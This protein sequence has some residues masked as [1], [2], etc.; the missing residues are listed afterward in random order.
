[1]ITKMRFRLQQQNDELE[2]LYETY[3]L[4]PDYS[5]KP[6]WY[7]GERESYSLIKTGTESQLT[8]M[9]LDS[10]KAYL[11]MIPNATESEEYK[12]KLTAFR[13]RMID[14][15]NPSSSTLHLLLGKIGA[16][17]FMKAAVM[18][19]DGEV[20]PEIKEKRGSKWLV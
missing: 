9:A 4:L 20:L 7:V 16:E 2:Q 11:S 6:N 18:P 10:V 19:I 8:S 15:G 3:R 1:M 5:E 13:Q 14:E 12:E 17:R